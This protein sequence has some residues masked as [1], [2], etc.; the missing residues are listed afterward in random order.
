MDE[1]MVVAPELL[2]GKAMVDLLSAVHSENE[3]KHWAD[4][5]GV[6][7]TVTHAYFA[8]MGGFSLHFRDAA[9]RMPNVDHDGS[10]NI[11]ENAVQEGSIDRRIS[12]PEQEIP[13]TMDLEVRTEERPQVGTGSVDN[14]PPLTSKLGP[15]SP[16]GGLSRTE[17]LVPVR[18]SH[19]DPS[20]DVQGVPILK[21]SFNKELSTSSTRH[22]HQMWCLD[23]KNQHMTNR[24]MDALMESLESD[25]SLR[26]RSRQRNLI[27][28]QGSVWVLD[29]AQLRLAREFGV[30]EHPPNIPEHDLEDQNKGDALVKALAVLQG[31]WLIVQL[32]VRWSKHLPSSQ[33]EL[34]AA[35]YAGCSMLTY[36]LFWFKPKDVGQPRDFPAARYPT[37]EEILEIAMEGPTTVFHYRE[38][39]WMPNNTVHRI[40][41]SKNQETDTAD[42]YPRIT[43][44]IGSVT[45]AIIFGTPHLFAWNFA[46]PTTVERL[47]WRIAAVLVVILP[48]LGLVVDL[49]FSF[50]YKRKARTAQTS[51]PGHFQNRFLNIVSKIIWIFALPYLLARVYMIAEVFRSL[52]YLPPHAFRTTWSSSVPHF[53]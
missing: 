6:E 51:L 11:E 1:P 3:M 53:G 29:A 37:A 45:S 42:R 17:G 15:S 48:V 52:C 27:A 21:D 7:W 4:L 20:G 18:P 38:G 24:A 22:G 50:F 26:L 39:Y 47:I 32:I 34:V 33:L 30:L 41:R 5:D 43:F 28:L 8:N 36:V 40:R 49:V 16:S 13:T 2:L 35:A 31:L 19:E 46:F 44:M 23:N 12:V 25:P 10:E 14:K 9:I